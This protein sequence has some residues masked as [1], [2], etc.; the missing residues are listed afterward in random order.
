[1]VGIHRSSF[2][3]SSD[4]TTHPKEDLLPKLR[5][6]NYHSH[7]FKHDFSSSYFTKQVLGCN[8][9][10]CLP[11]SKIIH[12]KTLGCFKTFSSSYLGPSSCSKSKIKAAKHIKSSF[13]ISFKSSTVF[14]IVPLM[15]S[16]LVTHVEPHA[17]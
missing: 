11:L 5:S 17:K 4:V 8:K 6:P 7:R 3:S 10:T 13:K 16:N 2:H 9:T 12:K 15:P 14:R 1:M